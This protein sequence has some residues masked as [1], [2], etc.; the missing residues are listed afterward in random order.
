VEVAWSPKQRFVLLVGKKDPE[1]DDRSFQKGDIIAAKLDNPVAN[2][3]AV[4]EN[5]VGYYQRFIPVL[6]N[7]S[8]YIT[9][10]LSNSVDVKLRI[11]EDVSQHDMIGC[12]SPGWSSI[13]DIPT[14]KIA[15]NCVLEKGFAMQQILQSRPAVIVLVGKSTLEMFGRYYGM[16]LDLDYLESNPETP[17]KMRVKDVYHLLNETCTRR[18]YF[19]VNINGYSLRSRVI[20]CPHF[21][22]YANYLKQARLSA[23]AWTAFKKDFADDVRILKNRRLVAENGYDN[24]T[25]IEIKKK[26]ELQRELS[27]SAWNVLMAYYYEPNRM[28]ADAL[29]EEYD[30]G[31]ISYDEVSGCLN[32]TDGNCNYCDNSHWQFPENGCR[33]GKAENSD[34]QPVCFDEIIRKMVKQSNGEG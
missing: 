30:S 33:Y 26:K 23:E 27:A 20:V 32:R 28:I 17:G 6:D 16:F 21:S 29:I 34:E 24:V 9:K 3:A 31:V 10:Q 22:Y 19:T 15:E 12:A 14:G 25:A 13:Y 2:R 7:L 5:T 11:G 4:Y 18:K 8:D 1:K